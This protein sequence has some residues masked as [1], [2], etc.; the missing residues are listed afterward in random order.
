MTGRKTPWSDAEI[1]ALRAGCGRAPAEEIARRLNRTRAAVYGKIRQLGLSPPRWGVWSADEAA[2]LRC[3]RRR[4]LTFGRIAQIMGRTEGAVYAA[5]GRL[6]LHAPGRD[7]ARGSLEPEIEARVRLYAADVRRGRP[8]KFVH[9]DVR[10]AEVGQL[11]RGDSEAR[12]TEECL[13]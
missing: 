3:L 2:E 9:Q 13:A 7:V 8:I 12:R 11:G 4:G 1:M 10:L 5:A 6:R